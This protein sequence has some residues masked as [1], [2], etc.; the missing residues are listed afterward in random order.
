MNSKSVTRVQDKRKRD[1]N[2]AN[3]GEATR[4]LEIS[5]LERIYEITPIVLKFNEISFGVNY[6]ND[7]FLGLTIYACALI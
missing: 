3:K 4:F 2:S 1:N 6:E 7:M 5:K